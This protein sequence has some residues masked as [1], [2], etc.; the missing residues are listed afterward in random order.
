MTATEREP[1]SVCGKCGWYEHGPHRQHECDPR[2]GAIADKLVAMIP[3]VPATKLG[4]GF[5]RLVFELDDR[6]HIR[7]DV[8]SDG[9]RYRGRP[10]KLE[11]VSALDGLSHEAAVDLVQTL[12]AWRTRWP[13]GGA[14]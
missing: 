1:L 10:F 9:R 8:G 7:F 14:E 11:D 6:T 4:Y 13:T 2:R 5:G 12:A 3:S